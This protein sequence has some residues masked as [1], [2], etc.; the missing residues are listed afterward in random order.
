MPASFSLASTAPTADNKW[1]FADNK[2][3]FA[4]NKWGFADNKW[5]FIGKR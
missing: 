5:G 4:D 2:W 3:G 1:G